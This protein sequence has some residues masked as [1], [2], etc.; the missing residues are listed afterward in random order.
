MMYNGSLINLMKES[1]S[2]ETSIVLG[3]T[4]LSKF[5]APKIGEL[6]SVQANNE[7]EIEIDKLNDALKRFKE[8]SALS[9]EQPMVQEVRDR[10]SEIKKQK[11]LRQLRSMYRQIN[12]DFLQ[13]RIIK[14]IGKARIR[15]P[16]FSVH[17][18]Q[19]KM[20]E[21]TMDTSLSGFASMQL[22]I[23]F[24]MIDNTDRTQITWMGNDFSPIIAHS[25]YLSS[26]G[27]KL[28]A[29]CLHLITEM[30]DAKQFVL[31]CFSSWMLCK[32]I[33]KTMYVNKIRFTTSFVG[34]VPDKTKEAIQLAQPDFGGNILLIKENAP[35]DWRMD[36]EYQPTIDPLIVGVKAGIAYLIDIFDTTPLE[37]YIARTASKDIIDS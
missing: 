28:T 11:Q 9:N 27:N 30:L 35:E 14:R 18:T 23:N 26:V 16:K 20:D 34:I 13:D 37:E 1:N 33:E 15:L 5:V 7:S 31:G 8:G 24:G 22:L 29:D 36:V 2:M 10:I 19:W 6:D 3:E 32:S 12:L 21:W 25:R 4:D 17:A